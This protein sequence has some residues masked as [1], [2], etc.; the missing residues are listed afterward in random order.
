M[1]T[2]PFEIVRGGVKFSAAVCPQCGGKVWPASALDAH[3]DR[4]EARKLLL[5]S[6]LLPLQKYMARMRMTNGPWD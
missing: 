6:Q 4:H 5:N 3:I 1:A 2:K